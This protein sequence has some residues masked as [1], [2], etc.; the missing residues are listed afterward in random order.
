MFSLEDQKISGNIVEVVCSI[1]NHEIQLIIKENGNLSELIEKRIAG[2]LYLAKS[3]THIERR[4]TI[5]YWKT[6]L[7]RYRIVSQ[8]IFALSAILKVTLQ[9][10][11]IFYIIR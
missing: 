3:M 6:S 4:E 9:L 10:L 5:G 2:A 11:I 1:L 7:K 8:I